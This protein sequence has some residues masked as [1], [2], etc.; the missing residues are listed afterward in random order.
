MNH[1]Y[2]VNINKPYQI[3]LGHKRTHFDMTLFKGAYKSKMNIYWH[4]FVKLLDKIVQKCHNYWSGPQSWTKI[5][6]VVLGYVSMVLIQ[7][8][9]KNDDQL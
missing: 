4:V 7:S 9:G 1:V 3:G 6:G 5:I 8:L 2:Q